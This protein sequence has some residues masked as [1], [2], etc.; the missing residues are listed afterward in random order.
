M[1]THLGLF[2]VT[3]AVLAILPG[4]NNGAI[5]RQA[6][7]HGRRAGVLAVAGSSTGILLWAA[8]AAVG[9]SAVLLANPHA[10]LTIRVAG[11]VLL[12]GLGLHTLLTGRRPAHREPRGRSYAAGLATSLGN[13]KAGVFAV[14]FLPQ[15]V[16]ADGPVLASSILLG[17]VWAAVSGSWFCL[18][19]L[20]LHRVRVRA[21]RPSTERLLRAATG[22]TMLGLGVAVTFGW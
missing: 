11:G 14:S 12:C 18:Y 20:A 6:L 17:L 9:L 3:V 16:T 8:A 19:V 13:P 15:F 7:L 4:A 1:P 10:Y 2:V 22:V 5:T 21:T